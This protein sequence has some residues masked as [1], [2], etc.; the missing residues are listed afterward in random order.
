[1]AKKL[2]NLALTQLLAQRNNELHSVRTDNSVLQGQVD[3]LKHQLA[4]LQATKS[5]AP[6]LPA[7]A[8]MQACRQ[9]AMLEGRT[10]RILDGK[11]QILNPSTRTWS[12]YGQVDSRG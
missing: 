6:I 11:I 12:N 5:Q 2:T 3:A 7:R 10:T 4:E 9:I 1:M 8:T